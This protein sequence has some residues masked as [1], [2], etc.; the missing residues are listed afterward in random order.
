MKPNPM[1]SFFSATNFVVLTWLLASCGNPAKIATEAKEKPQALAQQDLPKKKSATDFRKIENFEEYLQEPAQAGGPWTRTGRFTG[2]LQPNLVVEKL[3]K[4]EIGKSVW[5]VVALT[6]AE[7]RF[8]DH[9]IQA[10]TRYRLGKRIEGPD[11][12]GVA[13]IVLGGKFSSNANIQ[14][15]RVVV[16][17]D[18]YVGTNKILIQSKIFQI[19]ANVLAFPRDSRG[20]RDAGLLSV[21][22]KTIQGSGK[23]ILKGEAGASGKVG[24]IGATGPNQ[25]CKH[26]KIEE[27]RGAPGHNS[28]SGQV[29]GSGGELLVYAER[30]VVTMSAPGGFGGKAL[31]GTAR[32]GRGG[33]LRACSEEKVRQICAFNPRMLDKICAFTKKRG[34]EG[35]R[36]KNAASGAVGKDGK[37]LL[38]NTAL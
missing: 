8:Q 38:Y 10:P 20:G 14:A 15:Y 31:R 32:G 17:E 2:Y 29:G 1:N 35:R 36:G 24:A 21:N 16:T 28:V 6:N 27:T 11:M 4:N 3:V 19:N 34:P 25:S 12:E 37:V 23:V 33:L 22:S 30:N 7:G 9:D 26:W 5:R 18:L 13:D